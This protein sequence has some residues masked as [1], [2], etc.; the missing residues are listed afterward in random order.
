MDYEQI[1]ALRLAHPFRPFNLVLDDGRL[2]P[3][4]KPYYLAMS[5]T[6]RFITL[7]LFGEDYEVIRLD[8]IRDV[9]FENVH[10]PPPACGG[11]G[12]G[13]GGA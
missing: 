5:P 10:R 11:T 12:D 2:L 3:V 6:K 7:S 9:H 13:S 4:N 8:R 1:R